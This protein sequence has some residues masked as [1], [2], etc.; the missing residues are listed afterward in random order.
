[1]YG[2]NIYSADSDNDGLTDRDEVKIFKT[3]PN[4]PDMDG[5]GWTDGD[6]ARNGYNPKGGGMLLKID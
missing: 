2:T 4:N 5:D 1:M 3:D 6:E